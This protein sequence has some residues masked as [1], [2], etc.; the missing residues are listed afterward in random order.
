MVAER[1][2]GWPDGFEKRECVAPLV[3]VREGTGG[4]N[5]T[6]P[7]DDGVG[8]RLE[9]GREPCGPLRAVESVLNVRVVEER[10]HTITL[11]WPRGL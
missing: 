10:R 5:I 9:G 8:R 2:C 7:D 3:F 6:G 1:L 11:W 4:E